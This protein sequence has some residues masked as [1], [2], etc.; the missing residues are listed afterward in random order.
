[1]MQEIG[2]LGAVTGIVGTYLVF[3]DWASKRECRFAV[4]CLYAVSNLSMLAVGLL[5]NVE[6]LALMQVV[7]MVFTINGLKNNWPRGGK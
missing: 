4:F 7:Y 2:W 1:M 3:T 5:K 6:S